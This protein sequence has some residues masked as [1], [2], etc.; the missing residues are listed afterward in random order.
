MSGRHGTNSLVQH[1]Q[2][3]G[4]RHN[5]E[6]VAPERCVYG[7]GSARTANTQEQ[8]GGESFLVMLSLSLIRH[9]RTASLVFHLLFCGPEKQ[10]NETKQISHL[11]I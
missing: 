2:N 8:G 3:N 10:K 7:R 4:G 1:R 6:G 11:R 9:L 5:W